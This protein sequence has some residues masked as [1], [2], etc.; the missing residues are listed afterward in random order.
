LIARGIGDSTSSVFNE[1]ITILGNR[2]ASAGD[3]QREYFRECVGKLFRPELAHHLLGPTET[4]DDQRQREALTRLLDIV[5]PSIIPL[6]LDKLETEQNLKA[7]KRLL[8]LLRDCGNAVVP[9]A[10]QRLNHPQW[11]VVRNMLLLLRDL[12]A[13][14][15]IPEIVRCL[16]HA[17]AQVRLAAFQTLGTLAPSGDEFLQALKR[18]LDDDDPKVFRA[19]VTQLVST[20]DPASMALASRLLLDP[21]SGRRAA[22]QV[23]LLRVIEQIGT[24]AMLPLLSSVTRHH[25]LRFWTWRRTRLVRSTATRALAAIRKRE[26]ARTNSARG[27]SR[28]P[29]RAFPVDTGSETTTEA[30]QEAAPETAHVRPQDPV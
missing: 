15:A 14:Q 2:Y 21:S 24:P 6:L 3:D 16:R 30:D 10:I 1:A 28:E 11:F 8:S 18:A 17:S 27:S 4:S 7:R 25:L 29:T 9:L 13:V 12:L 20:P 19:A 22:Q 26:G 23:A 5:G